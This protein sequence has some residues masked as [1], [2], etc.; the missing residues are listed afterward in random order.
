MFICAADVGDISDIEVIAKSGF[1]D[2]SREDYLKMIKDIN[3]KVLVAKQ[4]EKI[5]GFLI[6]LRV[7]FKLE[8]IKVATDIHHKRQ[9]V[10]T[11]LINF[12]IDYGRNNG[13]QGVL[14]EVN[15]NN[16]SAIS[17]YKKFGFLQIHVRKKYYNNT[18]DAIIME[19]LF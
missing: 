14:L 10:A 15:E 17:L 2:Y 16:V 18:D 3:Y 7:D 9:G 5:V 8:I 6:F 12:M 19:L 1:D 13:H 4:G 11:S